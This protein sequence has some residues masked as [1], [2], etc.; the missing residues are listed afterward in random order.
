[1]NKKLVFRNKAFL[2]FIGLKII[3]VFNNVSSFI[4]SNFNR[5]ALFHWPLNDRFNFPL[6]SLLHYRLF[7]LVGESGILQNIHVRIIF[8]V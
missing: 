8:I 6:F 2:R 1:M 5:L 7:L 3:Q 4:C